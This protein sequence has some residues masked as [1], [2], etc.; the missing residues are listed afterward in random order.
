VT[1]QQVEHRVGDEV[2]DV[3]SERAV[4]RERPV[5]EHDLAIR[6]ADEV[7]GPDVEVAERARQALHR[8]Q[9]LLAPGVQRS[10]SLP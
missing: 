3:L 4:A 10:Q 1:E 9:Q 7:V 6:A 8:R 2:A 5:Q